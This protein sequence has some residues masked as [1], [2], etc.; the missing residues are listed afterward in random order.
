MFI[1]NNSSEFLGTFLQLMVIS[2]LFNESLMKL[3]GHQGHPVSQAISRNF[4]EF[5]HFMSNLLFYLNPKI[6]KNQFNC[7]CFLL[8]A[9]QNF[10]GL[11]A[12]DADL[13]FV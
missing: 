8:T 13:N 9:L 2:S 1:V 4:K 6:Q 11:F 3:L 10:S 7:K 5:L 12:V